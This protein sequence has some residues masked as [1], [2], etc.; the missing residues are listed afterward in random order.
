METL[1]HVKVRMEAGVENAGV[2][3]GRRWGPQ[4]LPSATG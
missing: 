2:G 4:Q 1:I 3:A